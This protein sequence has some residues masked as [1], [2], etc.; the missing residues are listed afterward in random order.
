L[1]M[2]K[3]PSNALKSSKLPQLLITAPDGT[4][5]VMKLSERTPFYER[6]SGTNYFYLSRYQVPAKEGIYSFTLTSRAKSAVTIAVGEQEIRGEVL[7][8]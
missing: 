7:R 4:K 5:T 8:G 1:I 2:D 6:Y 3:R